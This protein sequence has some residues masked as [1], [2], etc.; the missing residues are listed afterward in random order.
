M[1]SFSV[2]RSRAPVACEFVPAKPDRAPAALLLR[3]RVLAALAFGGFSLSGCMSRPGNR[4]QVS[5]AGPRDSGL[6][7]PK[8]LVEASFVLLGEIHDNLAGHA[9]RLDWLRELTRHR[10]WA[11]AMEQF[12]APEQYRLDAARTAIEARFARSTGPADRAA[13]ARELAEAAGFSFGSWDWTF[14]EPVVAL[15]LERNLPLVAAN[16]PVRRQTPLSDVRLPPDWGVGDAG[17][18]AEAIR[19]G[20][21]DLLPETAVEAMVRAQLARDA[22]MASAMVQARQRSGLPVALLA[23]NEHVRTDIGVPRHLAGLSPDA[24]RFAVGMD[25]HGS[26]GPGRFDLRLQVVPVQ[27]EDPCESLRRRW[28]R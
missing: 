4:D 9:L 15:A 28:G 12:D 5:P 8:D 23:G 21:C 25:E 13:A 6:R 24:K 14:Y 11:I 10:R 27:R 20:H 16:L 26:P 1:P 2:S 3:R 19:R 7:L 22:T 18:M 17:A